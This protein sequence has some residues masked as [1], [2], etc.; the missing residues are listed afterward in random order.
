MKRMLLLMIIIGCVAILGCS[1]SKPIGGDKDSHG[2]LIGAGYTWCEDK[3]KCIRSWEENCSGSSPAYTACMD[4]RPEFCTKE[5][6]PVCAEKDNGIRCIKAPCPSSDQ[7]TFGNGCTACSDPKVYGYRPGA[8]T[9]VG[10]DIDSHGCKTSAG[11]SWCEEK[12]KCIR[13]WEENCTTGEHICTA[14]ESTQI[15]CTMEYMPVC[16]K[17]VLNMG[18]TVYQTFGNKCSACA[19]MKVVGYVPGECPAEKTTFMC[20]DTK[21]NYM[22]LTEAVAAAKTDCKGD[23]ILDCT[24][25]KGYRRDST[26]CNPECYYSTPKCLAPSTQCEQTYFC[27]EG[28]G[29]FWLNMNLTKPGCNPACVVDIATGK[30]EINWRCTGL[31]QK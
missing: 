7:V 29:T 19:A 5:Y 2:C 15:A 1:Q 11:Y 9:V 13:P 28:T 4:P 27:N 16:G 31:V 30:A 14:E 12:Q 8:C 17:L 23:P 3:Q 21:G 6:I 26:A 18:K 25:P 22:T 24:C 10:N 20:G